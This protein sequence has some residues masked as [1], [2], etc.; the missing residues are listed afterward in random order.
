MFVGL[1]V[2]EGTKVKQDGISF[3]MMH[4]KPEITFQFEPSVLNKMFFNRK[5]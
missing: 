3:K 4:N 1:S 5:A 2:T